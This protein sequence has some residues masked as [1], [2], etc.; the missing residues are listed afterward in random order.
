MRIIER[1]TQRMTV[2][3]RDSDSEL[4]RESGGLLLRS[5]VRERLG[6]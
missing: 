5:L 1:E 2:R 4:V 3:E 6:G